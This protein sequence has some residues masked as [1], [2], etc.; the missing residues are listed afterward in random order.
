MAYLYDDWNY[1]LQSEPELGRGYADLVM[2]VQPQSRPRGMCD[3]LIEFKYV[4]LAELKLDGATL[5]A[6][7]YDEV[8]ALPAVQAA[9]DAARLRQMIGAGEKLRCA[10][11]VAVGFER[12]V[13]RCQ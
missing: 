8:V 7:P 12:L 3:L 6:M 13:W 9:L 5:R 10:V 2:T 11:V 1:I 4:K